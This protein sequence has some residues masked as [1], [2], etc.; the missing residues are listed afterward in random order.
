[1]TIGIRISDS[2]SITF[3][4]EEEAELYNKYY[5]QCISISIL[6]VQFL[7]ISV[8]VDSFNLVVWEFRAAGAGLGTAI[9]MKR[10]YQIGLT[11]YLLSKYFPKFWYIFL[12]NT[13]RH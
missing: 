5:L 1:M 4:T 7:K 3:L 13:A 11:V 8:H 12:L 10:A 6:N 9:N 2:P